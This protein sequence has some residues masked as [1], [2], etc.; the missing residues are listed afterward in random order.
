MAVPLSRLEVVLLLRHFKKSEI[1]LI[2][3]NKNNR[4]KSISSGDI[5]SIVSFSISHILNK[6]FHVV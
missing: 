6:L 3:L 2:I 5:P 4:T 1:K